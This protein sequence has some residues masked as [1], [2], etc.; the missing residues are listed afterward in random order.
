MQTKKFKELT[1]FVIHECSDPS[2]LGST[3]LNKVLWFADVW[4]Y[5]LYGKSITRDKYVKRDRGPVPAHILATLEELQSEK[6]ISV[7]EP[8]LSGEPRKYFS[9]VSPE[10]GTLSDDDKKLAQ[11]A[12]EQVC[13]HSGNA[14][15]EISHDIIWKA[16]KNGEEIPFEATLAS[17]PGEITEDVVEWAMSVDK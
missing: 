5:Q 17:I 3:K 15:S 7:R 13:A 1:H 16:A 11:H 12:L 10:D 14:I 9:L 8:E 4:A 6:K 2:R